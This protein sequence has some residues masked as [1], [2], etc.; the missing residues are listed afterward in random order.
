MVLL[1]LP[2]CKKN[3]FN[4]SVKISQMEGAKQAD[5]SVFICLFIRNSDCLGHREQSNSHYRRREK[6]SLFSEVCLVNQEKLDEA[7]MGTWPKILH[8][9]HWPSFNF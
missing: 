8:C 4:L 7:G 9:S 3:L 6:W 1:A 2:S 5:Y